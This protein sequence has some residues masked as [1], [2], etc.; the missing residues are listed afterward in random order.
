[1]KCSIALVAIF[2]IVQ[3][4]A[5]DAKFEIN[6]RAE[7]ITYVLDNRT[8][9]ATADWDLDVVRV[10]TVLEFGVEIPFI[11]KFL[12]KPEVELYFTKY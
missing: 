5:R 12:I 8:E 7:A 2:V 11:S 10:R 9:I 6:Q 1:M 4:F 3:A